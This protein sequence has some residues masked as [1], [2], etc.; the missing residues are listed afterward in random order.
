MTHI[1]CNAHVIV[2]LVTS[3]P[4]AAVLSWGFSHTQ[5]GT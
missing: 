2:S 4:Q 3:P 1:R 5:E